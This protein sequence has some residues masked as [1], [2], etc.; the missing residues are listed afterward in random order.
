MK[1]VVLGATGHLG[2][3]T[4]QRLLDEGHAVTAV[5]RR[6]SDNAFFASI[7]AEYVGGVSLEDPEAFNR[8]PQGGV[9]AVVH[10]AG[11]M[12]AHAG[13]SPLPCDQRYGADDM[14]RILEVIHG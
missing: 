8:L 4:A 13:T 9:D 5:G 1:V 14:N 7:G 2:A 3:Y 11:A 6:V 10:L 12:P